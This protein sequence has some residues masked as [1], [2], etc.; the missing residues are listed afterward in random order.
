MAKIAQQLD[1]ILEKLILQ[2]PWTN[3]EKILKK[4]RIMNLI[5]QKI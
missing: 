1:K 3:F 4:F 2:T 5:L